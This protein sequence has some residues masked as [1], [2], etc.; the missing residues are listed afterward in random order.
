VFRSPQMAR[1]SVANLVPRKCL[2]DRGDRPLTCLS[3]RRLELPSLKRCSRLPRINGHGTLQPMRT[4]VVDRKILAILER[5]ARI[6]NRAL[7]E[8]VGLSVS[9]C[10]ERV[11]RL[12]RAGIIVGYHAR[13]DPSFRPAPFE[14][15]ANVVLLDLPRS[16]QDAFSNLVGNSPHIQSVMQ[17]TGAFDCIIHFLAQDAAAWRQFCAELTT[18]G[19]GCDR[20]SFGLVVKRQRPEAACV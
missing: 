3:G 1:S 5:D 14:L 13:I 7:A 9:A 11:R 12:E 8:S 20:V 17:L 10:F 2:V 18:I 6:T 19:V 16:T 4:D 15:L